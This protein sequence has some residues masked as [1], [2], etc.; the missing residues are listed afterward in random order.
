MDS[1]VAEL[2]KKNSR[3]KTQRRKKNKS[4]GLQMVVVFSLRARL[5]APTVGCGFA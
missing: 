1:E 2:P 3:A 5:E 4:F